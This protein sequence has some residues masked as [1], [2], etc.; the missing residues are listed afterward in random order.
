MEDP[1]AAALPIIRKP[2]TEN[3]T[4]CPA[5]AMWPASRGTMPNK[6]VS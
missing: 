2:P 5:P 6:V 3:C 4:H 1:V